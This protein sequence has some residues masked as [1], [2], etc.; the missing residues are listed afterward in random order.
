MHG[1]KIIQRKHHLV[2]TFVAYLKLKPKLEDFS[3]TWREFARNS[4]DGWFFAHLR[5][6]N[7]LQASFVWLRRSDVE[8]NNG[9]IPSTTVP[10]PEFCRK[11]RLGDSKF[12]HRED[13]FPQ[14]S[15][16][17]AAGWGI[18]KGSSRRRI[19]GDQSATNATWSSHSVE[20]RTY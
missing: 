9:L 10:E 14:W 15:D 16:L 3:R 6:C 1:W 19:T 5:L 18:P 7:L 2:M 17:G 4:M 11:E 20:Q 8:G 13:L 12:R